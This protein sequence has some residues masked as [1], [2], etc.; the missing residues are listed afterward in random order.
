MKRRKP[1]GDGKDDNGIAFEPRC[2]IGRGLLKML[3]Y[4]WFILTGI[5]ASSYSQ[6]LPNREIVI[7]SCFLMYVSESMS[8]LIRPRLT[9][10][11]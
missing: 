8:T 10:T 5:S 6:V 7:P 2:G 9:Y 3:V 1:Y 4:G 11:S